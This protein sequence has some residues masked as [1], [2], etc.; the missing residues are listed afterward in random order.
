MDRWP[1]KIM[2][3]ALACGV[4][5]LGA[6]GGEQKTD[7]EQHAAGDDAM[8]TAQ[9]P[10]ASKD[11]AMRDAA[12]VELPDGFPEDIPLYSGAELVR[13][14]STPGGIIMVKLTSGDKVAAIAKFYQDALAK[15]GWKERPGMDNPAGGR[16]LTFE[17]NDI[18]LTVQLTERPD[19]TRISLNVASL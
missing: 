2:L 17:K 8:E 14:A 13:T 12:A 6:C 11:A 7:A 5:L 15:S 16:I 10:K 4:L 1:S 9:T 19:A 18:V 3:F